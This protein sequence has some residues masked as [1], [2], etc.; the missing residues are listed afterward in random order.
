MPRLYIQV[1]QIRKGSAWHEVLLHILYQPFYFPFGLG[2]SDAAYLG[3]K[4][5]VRG[6]ALKS[7]LPYSL[8]VVH[9]RN[10][11]LHVVR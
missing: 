4:A 3:N 7:Y 11:G 10:H 8:T 1:I 2:P 5:K 9:V 6:K